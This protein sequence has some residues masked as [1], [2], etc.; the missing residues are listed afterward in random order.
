MDLTG[1]TCM[2]LVVFFFF[3]FCFF[4]IFFFFFFFF[5]SGDLNGEFRAEFVSFRSMEYFFLRG[6]KV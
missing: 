5:T 3:F 6:V 2:N 1:D 4:F